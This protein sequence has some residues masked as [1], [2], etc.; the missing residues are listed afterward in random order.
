VRY[1]ARLL[2]FFRDIFH[3]ERME[4]DLEAELRSY[5]TMLVDRYLNRGLSLEHAHRQAR[6]EI[7]SMDNIKEQIREVRGGAGFETVW[8][9]TR[10]A[11][12]SLAKTPGF[13]AVALITLALGIGVNTA[14]FSVVYA[15][16]LRPLP[17]DHPEQLALVWTELHKTAPSRAPAS[18]PLFAEIQHRNRQLQDVAAIWA[19]NGTFTGEVSPEQ[20]KVAFVTPN[21]PALLG[22]RP[23]LGRLFL[24]SEEFAGG[25]PAIMLS[26]G[27]WQRRF[28]GDPAIVGKAVG[29]NRQS[30]TVVGVLPRDFQLRFPADSNAVWRRDPERSRRSLLSSAAGTAEA[31]CHHRAGTIRSHRNRV[32]ATRNVHAFRRRG[33][34]LSI[35]IAARRLGA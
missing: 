8:L 5:H 4:Q 34:Q 2:I 30:A 10:Y 16:L 31:G 3:R 22:F 25:R 18:G 35:G 12:R 23:A 20:V 24:P 11:W 32:S 14:I 29:I 13:A 19:G 17:Y 27:I 28:G 7:E 9:D 21:F 6:L 33:S 15:V 26:Y 1:L